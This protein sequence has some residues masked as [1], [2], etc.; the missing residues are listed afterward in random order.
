MRKYFEN[1]AFFILITHSGLVTACH[2]ALIINYNNEILIDP[3][4]LMAK[5]GSSRNIVSGILSAIWKHNVFVKMA[6]LFNTQLKSSNN[7]KENALSLMT[8]IIII[9]IIIVIII[10]IYVVFLVFKLVHFRIPDDLP[11]N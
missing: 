8:S 10:I 4:K 2:Y 9:S 7:T 5:V 6:L 1:I 11:P 3:C